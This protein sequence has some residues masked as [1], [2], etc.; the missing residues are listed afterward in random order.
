MAGPDSLEDVGDYHAAEATSQDAGFCI[1]GGGRYG[2]HTD[3]FRPWER[4]GSM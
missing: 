3:R 4:H 2:N 1:S